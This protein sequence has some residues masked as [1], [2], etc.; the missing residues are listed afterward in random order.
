MTLY[1][2]KNQTDYANLLYTYIY[3]RTKSTL[4][5]YVNG[6]LARLLLGSRKRANLWATIVFGIGDPRLENYRFHGL[7]IGLA[8][9]QEPCQP[10]LGM[11][12]ARH[13][14]SPIVTIV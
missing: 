9:E 3:T 12:R 10:R 13:D 11:K 1:L 5:F 6:Y 8:G 7:G 2:Y 4:I 14:T